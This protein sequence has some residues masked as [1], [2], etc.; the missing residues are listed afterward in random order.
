MYVYMHGTRVQALYVY[1][2]RRVEILH[3]HRHVYL[4]YN[5]QYRT[6]STWC[7]AWC[8]VYNVN[9]TLMSHYG[10]TRSATVRYGY[11]A[12]VTVTVATATATVL[13]P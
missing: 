10:S 5:V 1:V 12:T 11:P 4:H 2:R 8:V 7:T 6:A 13:Y 9:I 3:V